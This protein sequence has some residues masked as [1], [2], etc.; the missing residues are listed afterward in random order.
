VGGKVE[1]RIQSEG[2]GERTRR[3]ERKTDMVV[4]R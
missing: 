2:G 4:E 3:R 1:E